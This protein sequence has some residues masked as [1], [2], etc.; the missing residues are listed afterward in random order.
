MMQSE[1]TE[2]PQV[3]QKELIDTVSFWRR[4]AE[5]LREKHLVSDEAITWVM[6]CTKPACIGY[7]STKGEV[8][9]PGKIG[10]WDMFEMAR[11]GG[12]NEQDCLL[13]ADITPTQLADEE[14]Q[15]NMRDSGFDPD[16]KNEVEEFD[17]INSMS[18]Q[19]LDTE[20]NRLR[21]LLGV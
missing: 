1:K 6:I 14:R 10:K 21:N 19:E 9:R 15:E 4:H 20:I 2:F 8:I 13:M 7:D 11:Q 18:P 3:S 17:R 16:N 12:F 5:N